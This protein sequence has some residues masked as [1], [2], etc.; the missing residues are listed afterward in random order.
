[1]PRRPD[2]PCADCGKLMHRSRGSLPQGQARCHPCRRAHRAQE[3]AIA[4]IGPLHGPERPKGWTPGEHGPRKHRVCEVCTGEYDATYAAQRTCSRACAV[5]LRGQTPGR[6]PKYP[7]SRVW[8][9]N[10]TVCDAVFVARNVTALRCSPACRDAATR[11]LQPR[12][13]AHC[14]ATF[15]GTPKQKYCR[16]DPCGIEAGARRGIPLRTRLRV[17]ERDGSRCHLCGYLVMPDVGSRHP[18]AATLDHLVLHRD[19]GTTELRNLATAHY[20]CNLVRCVGSVHDARAALAGIAPPEAWDTALFQ[21]L[22]D[23]V[24]G[25]APRTQTATRDQHAATR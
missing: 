6:R 5:V 25:S 4:A 19:G 17:Y 15:I 21:F 1:M 9:H 12:I 14:E 11:R 10:C 24:P 8:I 13:C 20:W 22:R 2:L 16:W 7:R 18:W 3:A 23:L